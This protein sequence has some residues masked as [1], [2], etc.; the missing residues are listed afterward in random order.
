VEIG[1]LM[2]LKFQKHSELKFVSRIIPR[3][4][5]EKSR[6]A[7]GIIPVVSQRHDHKL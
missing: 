7:E 2:R 5:G 6:K 1:K 4:G 3:S